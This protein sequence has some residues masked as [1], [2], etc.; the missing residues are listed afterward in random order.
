M[1]S[2][3][4]GCRARA[5]TSARPGSPTPPPAGDDHRPVHADRQRDQDLHGHRA[6]RA[7]RRPALPRQG[8]RGPGRLQR[9]PGEGRQRRPQRRPARQQRPRPR[10][11]VPVLRT[12]SGAWRAQVHDQRS[13]RRHRHPQT[14]RPGRRDRL[15]GDPAAQIQGQAAVLVRPAALLRSDAVREEAAD[16]RFRGRGVA[17]GR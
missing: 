9:P 13:V 7:R 10:R 5:T 17:C 1:S 14:P 2:S 3:D 12:R 16:S 11:V 15:Q 4:C 8:H 6:A